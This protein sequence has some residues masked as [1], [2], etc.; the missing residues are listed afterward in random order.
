M[1]IKN[2]VRKDNDTL[3]LNLMKHIVRCPFYRSKSCQRLLLLFTSATLILS[4]LV[5]ERKER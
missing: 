4:V 5:N 2:D 3:R 1:P